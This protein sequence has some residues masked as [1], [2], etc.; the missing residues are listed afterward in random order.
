M[1]FEFLVNY[2]YVL[3]EDET[4]TDEDED[5]AVPALFAEHSFFLVESGKLLELLKN[6]PICNTMCE[7]TSYK[8]GCAI[9]VEHF[10]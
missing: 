3:S 10:F 1:K 6:C 4:S 7:L 9:T 8:K 2:Q 5:D